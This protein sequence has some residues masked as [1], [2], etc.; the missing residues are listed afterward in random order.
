[1]FNSLRSRL[2]I[3]YLI[4][5]GVTLLIVALA[6]LALS[7]SQSSRILPTLRQLNTI[8]Q[9]V[10]R[11]LV[12]MNELDRANL[13]SMQGLLEDVA[14]NQ[15]V[16]IVILNRGN[17][18]VIYDSL[19]E[20]S[21]WTGLRAG[22][23]VRPRGEFQNID[24]GIAVGRY[25][26]PDGE[27]WLIFSL[28]LTLR[29]GNQLVVV[30]GRLEPGPLR[31]FGETFFRPLFQAGVIALLVSILLAV[32]ISRSVARPL[33]RMAEAS[34]SIAQGEFDEQL[35]LQGPD[36]VRRLARSFNSMATQVDV[37]QLSQRD[38]VANV[39]HDLKTPLTAIQ[40]WSQ[41][42]LDGTAGTPEEQRGAIQVIHDE[43]D[44]MDRMVGQLLE[45]ARIESGQLQLAQDVVDLQR[46]I[47]EVEQA[48]LVKARERDVD[49]TSTV[50]PVPTI[51]G[52]YDR[53]MQA[54]SNLVDNALAYTPEHGKVRIVLQPY[55]MSFTD[56]IVSDSGPG[57]PPAELDRIFE[58]FYQV[59]KSREGTGER[60]GSGI[61]LAI[62][63]ELV[64]AHHG[65]VFAN[66]QP[67]Q[68]STFT[69][70]LPATTLPPDAG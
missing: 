43:A 63:K 35:P 64:E 7:I 44:R 54:V 37:T 48:H 40:G 45:L 22:E 67:G 58:R 10:R 8:S 70:R 11:E 31:F 69:I 15:D 33:Q 62:V 42:L 19:S 9:G 47:V 23:V 18:R 57:I 12:R 51:V 2:L 5:I 56:I 3:S 30:F 17:N 52:D 13:E 16:R 46:L 38:L 25:E 59:D 20:A 26:S 29:G 39:S 41:A 55:G 24:P 6:L 36:E 1:M 4:I 50:G 14:Q 53:L 32:L 66:S 61:G 27:R 65:E 34:E 28:P 49:L 21:P 60:R 68:G